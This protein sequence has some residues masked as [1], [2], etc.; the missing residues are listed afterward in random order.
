VHRLGVG[1][2]VKLHCCQRD[3]RVDVVRLHGQRAFQDGRFLSVTVE[4]SVTERDLL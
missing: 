4:N 3:F 2:P 1:F